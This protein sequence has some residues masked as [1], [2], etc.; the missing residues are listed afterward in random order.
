MR[1]LTKYS[2]YKIYQIQ[3]CWTIR[4]HGYSA[5]KKIENRPILIHC[6]KCLR[7]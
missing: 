3:F 2:I 4:I 7:Q 5:L 1:P 6:G